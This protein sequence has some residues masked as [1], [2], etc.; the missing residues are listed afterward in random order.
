MQKI[1]L[2]DG[3]IQGSI[4]ELPSFESKIMAELYTQ[5]TKKSQKFGKQRHK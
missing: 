3:L 2:R 4:P 1:L 5:T